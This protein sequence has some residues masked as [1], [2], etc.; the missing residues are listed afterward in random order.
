MNLFD[1]ATYRAVRRPLLQAETLPPECYTS[2]EFYQR[3][4]SNIFMKVWNCVG[5]EDFIKKPGDYFTQTIVGSSVIVIRGRDNKIRAFVNACR[6]RGA[7]LV[8]GD[9]RCKSLVCPYHAWTY[10]LDGKLLAFSFMEET[11]N[12]DAKD[13]G[14]I[15][16]KL[17]TWQGFIFV[18]F[19][20]NCISLKEFLGD[21]DQYTESYG[22]ADMVT[23][24][25]RDWVFQTNWKIYAESSS[26][27]IHLPMVHKKSIGHVMSRDKCKFETIDGGNFGVLRTISDRSRAVLEGD[28]GFDKIP[29]LRGTA[30]EGAQYIFIN[31]CTTLGADLDCMWYKTVVPEGINQVRHITGFCFPKFS[32]ERPDAEEILKNYMKRFV[33]VIEE[34]ADITE[35]Q[36]HGLKNPLARPGRFAQGEHLVHSFDNWVLDQVVGREQVEHRAAAE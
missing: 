27:G 34:D 8:E 16:V 10:D 2:P 31:P 13:Y 14:L 29:G 32:L 17:D 25:R 20:P 18:N 23:V 4:V 36:F 24:G 30:A 3:E 21:L 28:K 22:F 5:R 6:H 9:G 7:R 26:E 33:M 19:D 12:L 35:K 1:P 15:E 11:E